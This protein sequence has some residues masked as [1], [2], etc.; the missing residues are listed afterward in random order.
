[1]A[2]IL[3]IDDDDNV[4]GL[5]RRILEREGHAVLEAAN[6]REGLRLYRIAPTEIVI[7]DIL[8]PEQNGLE[9]IMALRK[10][11][12]EVKI[13]ALSGGGQT[14]RKNL[15]HNAEHLGAQYA[16]QKP[17]DI[18]ELTDVVHKLLED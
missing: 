11:F 2:R 15:L 5:L 4:R 12:P 14:G 17:F 18:Q 10:E 9:T 3:I 6:G 16:L 1:M 7:T 8:M 13:I